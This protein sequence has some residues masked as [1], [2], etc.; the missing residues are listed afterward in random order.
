[1]AARMVSEGVECSARCN[2]GYKHER[3][4]ISP[5]VEAVSANKT[6]SKNVR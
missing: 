5:Y 3:A 1:M 4:R 2:S 6:N